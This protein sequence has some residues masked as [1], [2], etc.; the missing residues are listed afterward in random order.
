MAETVYSPN[1]EMT[2]LKVSIH[3]DKENPN[4]GELNT[5]VSV[6]D[7]AGG[8]YLVLEQCTDDHGEQKLRLDYNEFLKIAEAA[9]MLMHQFYI[10]RAELNNG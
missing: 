4:F 5:Y 6:E 2:I 9:K 10:E 8:P 7:D 3:N 1:W